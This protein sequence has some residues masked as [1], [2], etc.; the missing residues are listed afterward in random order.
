V[1]NFTLDVAQQI[2]NAATGQRKKLPFATAEELLSVLQEAEAAHDEAVS[3]FE[4]LHEDSRQRQLLL[5]LAPAI[6]RVYRL[7]R[8]LA[9]PG[10]Q[11]I[12]WHCE[13]ACPEDDAVRLRLEAGHTSGIERELL[14]EFLPAYAE[15]SLEP[16]MRRARD[17][18]HAISTES[19]DKSHGETFDGIGEMVEA[20]LRR[21]FPIRDKRWKI[22]DIALKRLQ[23]GA[24]AAVEELEG[25]GRHRPKELAGLE[26]FTSFIAKAWVAKPKTPFLAEFS[27][28]FDYVL[29]PDGRSDYS[30]KSPAS[31]F[32]WEASKSLQP[33]MVKARRLPGGEVDYGKR[34]YTIQNC[35]T[36]MDY[37]TDALRGEKLAANS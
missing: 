24:E 32:L 31:K 28:K 6:A 17:A 3:A 29:S 8:E 4:D 37:V 7:W 5:D 35:E 20:R 34:N 9:I 2:A 21:T 22:Y 30:P 12:L 13:E 26:A 16:W 10:R 18:A 36:V 25:R 14:L 1:S 15:A 19:L 23:H 33:P 11:T 27:S